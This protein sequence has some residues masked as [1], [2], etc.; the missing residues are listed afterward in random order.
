[1]NEI[2][3]KTKNKTVTLASDH[4]E[5]E[6]IPTTAPE[7]AVASHEH[8]LKSDLGKDWTAC[9]Q[10]WFDLERELGYGSQPGTKVCLILF[11]FFEHQI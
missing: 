6:N 2:D 11:S 4:L 10:A 7:W 5:K 1:M 8:L 3:G 9:V